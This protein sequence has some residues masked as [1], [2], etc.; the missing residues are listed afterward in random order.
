MDKEYQAIGY[1]NNRVEALKDFYRQAKIL[2]RRDMVDVCLVSDS[3]IYLPPQGSKCGEFRAS[4]TLLP[5]DSN[6]LQ[7]KKGVQTL[8]PLNVDDLVD[9]IIN[10]K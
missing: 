1:G 7:K 9:E 4:F 5:V 10:G 3:V 8:P 6:L 2:T